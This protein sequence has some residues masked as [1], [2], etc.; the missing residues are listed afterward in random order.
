[1]RK[2]NEK[3]VKELEDFSYKVDME[4]FNYALENYGPKEEVLQE[5][6]KLPSLEA[7]EL[8]DDLREEYDIPIN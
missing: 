2:L 7:E 4:G 1:M 5:F 3:E 6:Y 8:L